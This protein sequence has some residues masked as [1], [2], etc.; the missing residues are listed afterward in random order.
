MFFTGFGKFLVSCWLVL[1]SFGLV[2]VFIHFGRFG[3]VLQVIVGS[4]LRNAPRWDHRCRKN[5]FSISFARV[6]RARGSKA[7]QREHGNSME[8]Q[9][10]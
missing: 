5:M 2:L 9:G 4:R 1:L 3:W 8:T 6:L 10:I 7:L